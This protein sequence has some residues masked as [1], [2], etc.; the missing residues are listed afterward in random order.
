M[1]EEKTHFLIYTERTG[2][3]E[4]VDAENLLQKKS[5]GGWRANSATMHKNRINRQFTCRWCGAAFEAMHPGSKFCRPNHRLLA[6]RAK[7]RKATS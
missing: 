1:Q 6:W 4:A 2:S 5:H 7:N 3:P